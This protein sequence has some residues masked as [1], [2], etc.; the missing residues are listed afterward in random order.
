MNLCLIIG[1]YAYEFDLVVSVGGRI[2]IVMVEK[3][4]R[5]HLEKSWHKKCDRRVT[6]FKGLHGSEMLPFRSFRKQ[7]EV[8]ALP[9]HD[10]KEK[11]VELKQASLQ[12][13]E[14]NG[15]SQ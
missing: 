11:K 13:T 4:R 6:I 1:C 14:L 12:L 3:I 15:V 8:S 9:I 5:E 10:N 2:L 7:M